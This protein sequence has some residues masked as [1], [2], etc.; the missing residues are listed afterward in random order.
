[1]TIKTLHITN[2]WHSTSGGIAT[3][4]R[5]LLRAACTQRRCMTLVV[6]AETDMQERWS[7]GVRL[8]GIRARTAP[9]NHDYRWLS[10]ASYLFPH[11]P[12]KSILRT[13]QPDL[14]EICDKYAFPPLA[15]LLRKG[16]LAGSG[17]RPTVVGLS[18]ERMD[19]NVSAYLTESPVARRLSRTY[20][21]WLY[22]PMCDH[23]LAVSQYTAAEL[24]VA[25]KG[26]YVRRGVWI[27]PMG[28]DCTRFTP[29]RRSGEIR[30][31]LLAQTGC[32]QRGRLLLYA[33]RLAPEKNLCLLLDLMEHLPA[34][35]HRMIIAGDG[36]L[37]AEF[38]R[39]AEKRAPG[40]FHLMGHVAD[41]QE[42]ADL[43]A[44]C[45]LFVHPNPREPFGIAPLEAMASGLPLLAPKAGGLTAYADYD[46]AWLTLPDAK[47]FA[48]TAQR[49]FSSGAEREA[50]LTRARQTAEHHDWP[51]VAAR[52]LSLYEELHRLT[53]AACKC[54]RTAPSFYSTP[55]DW[56]GR[57]I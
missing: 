49:V 26:H 34:G 3:F 28:V 17:R 20:M 37:R 5:A 44:N 13:E 29:A 39:E 38:V 45:D 32:P 48:T 50:K 56:L 27:C 30:A 33:G 18:C 6:P 47:A 10:P 25:S 51:A 52:Y 46:N 4:Y 57:E 12:L 40:L 41:R 1:M 42:L 14:V 7:E 22:F 8:Y 23:H 9:L 2:A 11:G 15:G 54:P 35:T 43:Y 36:V 24:E 53:E 16:W 21:K 55:G 31:R 19:D